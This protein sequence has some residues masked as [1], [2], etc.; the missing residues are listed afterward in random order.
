MIKKILIHI[1]I[2]DIEV[3]TKLK[4]YILIIKYIR[5]FYI[6]SPDMF[7]QQSLYNF[8]NSNSQYELCA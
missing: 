3:M 8:S 2:T 1:V 6:T 5:K 7:A 4:K